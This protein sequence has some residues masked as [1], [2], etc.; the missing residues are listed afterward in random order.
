MGVLRDLDKIEVTE[1]IHLYNNSNIVG[2]LRSA[3]YSPNLK[4][5]VG[6][7]MIKK[8][9]WDKKTPIE[10]KIGDKK[11]KGTLCDLPIVQNW[12]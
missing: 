8:E 9:Y 5:V 10:L 4:K 11:S 12:S 6:I 1:S 3:T 2:D 7:A